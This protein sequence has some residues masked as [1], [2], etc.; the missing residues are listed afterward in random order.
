MN[1]Q[2]IIKNNILPFWGGY[3][4]QW[5][6]FDF[7]DE[8]NILYKSAEQYMMYRKALTF[9]DTEMSTAILKESHPEKIKAMGRK[10]AN[11][12]DNIWDEHKY[13]IVFSGNL[14]KFRQNERIKKLL[15]DTGGCIIVEASHYDK[16]WG[17]GIRQDDD[18][19]YDQKKWKGENLLGKVLMGVREKIK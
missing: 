8:D 18:A 19:I 15:I 1:N 3:M 2:Y 10:V 16:I 9:L 5:A 14:L 12:D 6:Y 7:K 4:S 13:D 11:F 17:V